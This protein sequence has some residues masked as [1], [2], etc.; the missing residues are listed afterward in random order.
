[1]Y[2]YNDDTVLNLTSRT[3]LSVYLLAI[4]VSKGVF[5]ETDK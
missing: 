5:Y 2:T 4:Q 3:S 1:M